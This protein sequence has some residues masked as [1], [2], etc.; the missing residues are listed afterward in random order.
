MAGIWDEWTDIVTGEIVKSFAIITTTANELLQKI[1]HHR[2]PVIIDKN[3]YRRWLNAEHLTSVTRLLHPFPAELMAGYPISSEI[4]NPMA[5]DIS[6]LKPVGEML[7]YQKPV[8]V[9]QSPPRSNRKK[10]G[11]INPNDNLGNRMKK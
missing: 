6:L 4:K 8:Q 9:Y 3:D 7:T 11:E 5:K 2:S 10:G 1:P